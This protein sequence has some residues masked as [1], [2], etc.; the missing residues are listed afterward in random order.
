[1]T[2]PCLS[3]IVPC[4][5]VERY[6]PKCLDSLMHQTLENIEVICVN[7]GSPD[8]CL[9]I[10]KQYHQQ[11][12]KRIVIVDKKNEGP[13]IARQS[14][15]AIAKGEYIGF[16]DGDDYVRDDYAE[17]L[18][19]AA[20]A[21]DADIA[22]C[23]FDRVDLDTGKLYSREMCKP[24]RKPIIP[25]QNPG[26][27]IAVNTAVWNKIYRADLL[28]N[29]RHLQNLPDIFEDLMQLLVLYLDTRKIVFVPESL[30]Y[31][32]V[33]KD[34]AIHSVKPENITTTYAT[35]KEIR[36]LYTNEASEMLDFI[37]AIAFLHLGVSLMYRLYA[38]DDVDFSKILHKN[39]KFLNENFPRWRKTNYTKLK[40][41]LKN[42]GANS[43]LYFIKWT[44]NLG[45]F[46]AFLWMY[47]FMIEKI[48]V[49]IKW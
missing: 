19:R 4:Y 43:K 20:K 45:V 13:M 49:D 36:D 10:I 44:Y 47:N 28:K 5:K 18:Y 41:V 38:A 23:G 30:I 3:I 32:M 9:G 39:T 34:S 2:T 29:M 21:N 37:D 14:G 24:A 40:Y 31:Y 8:G 15:V 17:K 26:A 22:V 33:H 7:D 25:H 6:L 1:M 35:L 11:Y 48:G 46:R 12:G 16:I 42:H 27:L